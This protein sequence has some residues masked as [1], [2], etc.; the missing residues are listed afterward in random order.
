MILGSGPRSYNGTTGPILQTTEVNVTVATPFPKYHRIELELATRIREGLY[1]NTGLPG[2]RE[3]ALEFQAARVTIRSA[4]RRLEDQGM[5]MRMQRH[6]TLVAD[7]KGGAPPRRMLREHVDAFLGRGRKGRRK[8]LHF[9]FV[10]APSHVAKALRI[11]E[12]GQVLRVVR[13]RLDAIG[14]MTYTE[15]YVPHHLA[16][17]IT[18]SALERKAFLQLLEE[19][20]VRI[21]VAE[22]TIRADGAPLAACRVLEV[23]LHSPILKLTRLL[24]D[25]NGRAVQWMEGWYRPDRFELRMQMSRLED[26]TRAWVGERGEGQVSWP[27]PL[28][29]L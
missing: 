27:S 14:P 8:V 11:D 1:D 9:G 5:V 15:A 4:L 6:G 29:D 23:A 18:R 7:S 12:R 2:E 16:W 20:G 21:T 17:G 10:R 3:L 22:Q 25:H 24:R 19:S 28:H 26:A 13:L